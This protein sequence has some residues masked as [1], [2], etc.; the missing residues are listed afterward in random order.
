[1]YSPELPMAISGK[2]R[3]SVIKIEYFLATHL[4]L[5]EFFLRMI[6]SKLSLFI[7]NSQI[8]Y[9]TEQLL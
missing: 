4:L 8:E 7:Q 2:D 6:K 3:Q 9:Q 5:K 1:M